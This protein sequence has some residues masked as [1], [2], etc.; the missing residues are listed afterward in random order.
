MLYSG[1]KVKGCLRLP[2]RSLVCKY[3][4]WR[5]LLRVNITATQGFRGERCF[6]GSR[7]QVPKTR[8]HRGERDEVR[9]A[10]QDPA[11]CWAAARAVASGRCPRTQAPAQ[12]SRQLRG[13]AHGQHCGEFS[14]L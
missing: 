3:F 9:W 1:V 14:H 12:P 7:A 13:S 10:Q 4:S 11:C 6:W 8:S 2:K 5:A